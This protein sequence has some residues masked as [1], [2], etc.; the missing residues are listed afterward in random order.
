MIIRYEYDV[1]FW[2]DYSTTDYVIELPDRQF[3]FELY[4][5]P[6][7]YAIYNTGDRQPAGKASNYR[8]IQDNSSLWNYLVI[9]RDETYLD[10]D[11]LYMYYDGG[12]DETFAKLNVVKGTT[13]NETI[14]GFLQIYVV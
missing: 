11:I 3:E 10:Y 12:T 5:Y 7:M 4:V 2:C 9:N 8:Y 6:N 13:A 1:T 14:I